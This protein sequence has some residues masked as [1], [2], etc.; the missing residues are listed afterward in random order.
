MS[1]YKDDPKCVQLRQLGTYRN[2][3]LSRLENDALKIL[4]ESRKIAK[5]KVRAVTVEEGGDSWDAFLNLIDVDEAN[6]TIDLLYELFILAAHKSIEHHLVRL[7]KTAFKGSVERE[8]YIFKRLKAH[9]KKNKAPLDSAVYFSSI[10][11]IRLVA[12]SIKHGG[13]V[14]SELAALPGWNLGEKL[15]NLDEFYDRVKPQIPL[16]IEHSTVLVEEVSGCYVAPSAAL[17]QALNA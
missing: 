1:I 10:N 16:F 13:L 4:L 17:T 12:N 7:A 6:E 8:L 2:V 3:A 11:E 14:S 5:E 15:K 9:F